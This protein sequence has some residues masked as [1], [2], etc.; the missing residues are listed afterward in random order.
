MTK[1]NNSS[2]KKTRSN[3]YSVKNKYNKELADVI[4][5]IESDKNI[6]DTKEKTVRDRSNVKPLKDNLEFMITDW[7][8]YHEMDQEDHHRY[9]TQLFGRTENDEDV[10]VKVTGFTPYFYVEVPS[11]W[12][13]IQVDEFIATIKSKGKFLSENN[14]RYDYD[15]SQSL[16]AHQVVLKKKF[17][18]FVNNKTYKFIQLVFKS[19][20]G[21]QFFANMLGRK[22]KFNNW[23]HREP[24]LFNI[25]ESNIE[26]HLR[27]MHTNNIS[28]CG[29]VKIPVDK[30]YE[31][32]EY[33]DC[34]YSYIAPWRYVQPAD[35]DDRIA[36][37]KIM[38]YDIECI[39][40]DSNFPQANR[41][42]DKIIQI[43]VTMF[44]Y[45][46]MIAY[47]K[48]ILTLGDC[49]EIDGATLICYKT[50]RALLKGFAKLMKEIRPDIKAGYNN[51]GFDDNYIHDRIK[52]YDK[53]KAK[54]DGVSVEFMQDSL[55]K[56]FVEIM[57]KV[58][59][60]YLMENENI[61]KSLTEYVEKNLSSSALGDNILKFF[62]VPG[63]LTV[64]MLKV[65]QRDHKLNGYKLDNVSANFITEKII[66]FARVK[67]EYHIYTRS[68][69]ALDNDSY[70]QIM[71]HDAYSGSPYNDGAKFHVKDIRTI[72][73]K[74]G[75]KEETYQVI[76]TSAS[77]NEIA[78]LQQLKDDKTLKL[79]WTFAKDD[80][81]H[82]LINKY[83]KEKNVKKIALIAKYC[84]KDC[85]L[86]NLLL[87]KLEIIVNSVGMAKVCHVPL[88]YLFMRGQGVKI[89]SL[90]SKK[91]REKGFLIP[92]LKVKR[93]VLDGDSDETYEGA[94]V[95]TPKPSVYLSPIAVL[96]YN[97]LYPQSMRECNLT[98]ECY[99]NDKSYDNIKGYIYHDIHIICKDSE[100]KVI[101]NID[102]TSKKEHHRFA[103]EIVDIKIIDKELKEVLEKTKNKIIADSKLD[104]E[105]KI[106]E[107][108][109]MTKNDIKQFEDEVAIKITKG[110]EAERMKKFN[111]INGQY[112][113]YGILPEILTELLNKRKEK[114][115]EL[116]KATDSFVKAILNAL[117]L[118]YKITANSLYGQT[119]AK[120]SAIFFIFIA[121]CTTCIGR[122]RL[123]LAKRI[124]IENFPG[125]EVIYGDTDS[126]FIN[127]HIKDENGVEISDK[128]ALIKTIEL[129]KKAAAII[130]S[131]VPSPQ[132]IVYEKT[133]WPFI[134]VAKKKYVGM[135]YGED[136]N[137]GYMKAMGIV[138]KR[139]DN[140]PIVKIVVGGIIDYIMQN[141]DIEGAVKYTKEV[142]RKLLDGFY[143]MD[144]FII[145]KTLKAKYKKPHTITHKVLADRMAERDPGNKPQINDRIP[146]VYVITKYTNDRKK[147]V[148]QGQLVE[149]PE[150]VINNKLKMDYLYY[151]EHQII[152]PA[153]Q[154]LELL[155]SKRKVDKLFEIF[156]ENELAKRTGQ[157]SLES[158]MDPEPQSNTKNGEDTDTYK[159]QNYENLPEKEKDIIKLKK[160]EK[161]SLDTWMYNLDKKNNALESSEN[162]SENDLKKDDDFVL[163]W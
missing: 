76:V 154:F 36:S 109:N 51:K 125:A 37:L 7:R 156:V 50:E 26:P 128:R 89:F 17:Y 143:P 161:Q 70:I 48:Y 108:P 2:L 73:E 24:I 118:A 1:K 146:F 6:L 114:N 54:K 82:T 74:V 141:A 40:C 111:K 130:N 159:Y 34:D 64:D 58:N 18:N 103:Q 106:K 33:S 105:K 112:V 80:M 122:E 115:A 44:R 63:I 121:A 22:L 41:L 140:A 30:L 150:Y 25:Y 139:R 144:K 96:D 142:V 123:H 90:V 133:L 88:S 137:F 101:R 11:N 10:C 23:S 67:K 116:A 21:M 149:H 102:G 27:L 94:T 56:I 8:P 69:K 136:P 131:N 162:D 68:T 83:F 3:Q 117:Q 9:V 62:D 92:L 155:M 132:C 12:G 43:G 16:I 134:L 29:W 97:S 57:G 163:T 98:P 59:N 151:L 46:S 60:K 99:V 153:S 75:E 124:V 14:D 42:S 47:E 72:K 45:G 55:M 65:I 95:I 120:T 81:H 31:H 77:D 110:L 66:K 104:L 78:E 86:V 145:S 129:A 85:A 32:P 38:G 148:L 135:L 39:S 100:G 53:I 127:F 160:V 138:L 49:A 113:R 20:I 119:G 15:M 79:V 147:R 91:C 158:W 126:I 28:S 107:N 13:K 52:L 4:S 35:N 5:E 19:H 157:K 71:V 152:E 87:A 84:L 93:T 61:P